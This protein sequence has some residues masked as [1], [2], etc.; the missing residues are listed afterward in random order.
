M[1]IAHERML[2]LIFRLYISLWHKYFCLF[3]CSSLLKERT[4]TNWTTLSILTGW[5]LSQLY[6]SLFKPLK[7]LNISFYRALRLFFYSI[8]CRHLRRLPVSEVEEEMKPLKL[9]GELASMA[10]TIMY[11]NEE[12]AKWDVD[13]TV[14]IFLKL[15]HLEVTT[16]ACNLSLGFQYVILQAGCKKRRAYQLEGVILIQDQ[17]LLFYSWGNLWQSEGR[18][19]SWILG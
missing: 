9:Q 18:I 14:L 11:P 13:G 6:E 17:I 16:V 8:L 15:L 5:Y 2:H 12:S 3:F 10:G 19:A 1:L 7:V 4:K